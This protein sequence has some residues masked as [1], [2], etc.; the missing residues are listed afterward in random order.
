MIGIIYACPDWCTVGSIQVKKGNA[1]GKDLES[2]MK[3]GKLVPTE[4]TVSLLRQAMQVWLHPC[5][6][7]VVLI[8]GRVQIISAQDLYVTISYKYHQE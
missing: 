5:S 2:M 6:I 8:A 4:V 7:S 1:L 3:E